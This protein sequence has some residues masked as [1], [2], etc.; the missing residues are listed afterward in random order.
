M[1]T[2]YSDIITMKGQKATSFNI[3]TANGEA[4]G[5]YN[6]KEDKIFVHGVISK[7]GLKGI[8]QI[9]INKFKTNKVVFTP[10]ITDGIPSTVRGE[11]K[12]LSA[13][14]PENPYGEE[15]KYMECEWV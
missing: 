1:K 8:M 7:H 11:I 5:L 2:E 9:L 12:V 3:V 14:S 6:P 15:F 10:L 4:H 13:N